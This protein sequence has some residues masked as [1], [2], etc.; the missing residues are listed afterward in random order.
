MKISGT[1]RKKVKHSEDH[2]CDLCRGEIKTETAAGL[3]YSKDYVYVEIL[4]MCGTSVKK[5]TEV[6]MFRLQRVEKVFVHTQSVAPVNTRRIT[7]LWE[8]EKPK[9]SNC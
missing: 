3:L 6:V 5:N 7:R 4:Y 1:D 8:S 9:V 2:A